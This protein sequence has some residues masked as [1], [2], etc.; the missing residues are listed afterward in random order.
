M[1]SENP[2]V[3]VSSASTIM[4]TEMATV[5]CV[6]VR[7]RRMMIPTRLTHYTADVKISVHICLYVR[8]FI[9]NC[10]VIDDI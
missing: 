1:R 10:H 9:C 4:A 8:S 2:T 6:S 5:I 7:I 3:Y